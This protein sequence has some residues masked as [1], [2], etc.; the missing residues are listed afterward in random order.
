MA[1]VIP[2]LEMGAEFLAEEAGSFIAEEAG[3]LAEEYLGEEAGELLGSDT[4]KKII[5]GGLGWGASKIFGSFQ[6]DDE[7]EE[8]NANI[9]YQANPLLKLNNAQKL[10]LS[11]IVVPPAKLKTGAV[12][13]ATPLDPNAQPVG[14]RLH[15]KEQYPKINVIYGNPY[16]P[17]Q[18]A[19]SKPYRE[20]NSMYG[21]VGGFN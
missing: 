7:E 5:G 12:V 17:I 15:Y 6:P 18:R 9:G 19:T 11:S 13:P 4:A 8:Y 10:P 2:F 21:N 1:F 3:S 16:Y 14:F 20:A